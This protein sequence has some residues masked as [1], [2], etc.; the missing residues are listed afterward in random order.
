MKRTLLS[1]AFPLLCLGITA[2][3]NYDY[4]HLSMEKLDRG[5]IAVRRPDGKVFISW[6]I[7]RDDKKGEAFDIYRNGEKL[8]STSLTEGGSWFIDEHPIEGDAIYEVRCKKDEG[9]GKRDDVY[10]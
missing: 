2:Q 10:K 4:S 7:L 3:T 9:R 6:R 1:I 5:V 8:N